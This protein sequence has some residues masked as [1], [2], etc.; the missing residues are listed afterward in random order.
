MSLPQRRNVKKSKRQRY[1]A[2]H[3]HNRHRL[4][5]EDSPLAPGG[6]GLSDRRISRLDERPV[7][8]EEG[9]AG[10]NYPGRWLETEYLAE[11][12]EE[13][14]LRTAEEGESTFDRPPSFLADYNDAIGGDGD[15]G[16][17]EFLESEDFEEP[18]EW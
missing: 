13:R 12:L 3:I 14:L 1:H 15:Y 2:P 18:E 5:G 8:L 11:N 6:V 17:E 16:G 9:L 4:L 7:T 10:I